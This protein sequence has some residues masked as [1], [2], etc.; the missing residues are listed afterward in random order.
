MSEEEKSLLFKDLCM[1]IPYGV[2]CDGKYA[3]D[4]DDIDGGICI[5]DVHGTLDGVNGD[6]AFINGYSCDIDT[7][8][9][10][11]RSLKGMSGVEIEEFLKIIVTNLDDFWSDT[12]SSISMDIERRNKRCREWLLERQYDIN[13]LL[14]IDIAVEIK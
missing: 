7:V 1:R 10:H 13:G 3:M 4:D 6:T 11:L 5:F 14:D 12:C 9:P 2:F 8:K